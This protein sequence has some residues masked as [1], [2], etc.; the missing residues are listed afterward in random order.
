MLEGKVAQILN[1]RELVINLGSDVGVRQ[2]HKFAVLAPTPTSI[3]DPDTKENLG[4]VDREKV[5]VEAKE[6]RAKFAI[7]RTYHVRVIGG[8]LSGLDLSSTVY[9]FTPKHEVPVTLKVSDSDALPPLAAEDSYV[10][11]GDRVKMVQ[12]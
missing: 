5:R 7:C 4:V 10:K 9:L 3:I 11:I 1:E 2:G 6:V 12:E 8:A